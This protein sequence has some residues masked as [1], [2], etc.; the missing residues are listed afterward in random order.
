MTV[1]VTVTVIGATRR[2]RRLGL[3]RRRGAQHVQRQ[4]RQGGSEAHHDPR[5]GVQDEGRAV[6]PLVALPV[7]RVLELYGRRR[8]IAQAEQVHRARLAGANVI[9]HNGDN[10]ARQSCSKGAGRGGGYTPHVYTLEPKV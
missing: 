2:G 4:L 9:P 1:T 10:K 6:R 5:K 3:E 8:L 7:E